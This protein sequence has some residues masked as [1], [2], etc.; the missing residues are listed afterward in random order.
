MRFH[1]SVE[2]RPTI[3]RP[4]E[5]LAVRHAIGRQIAKISASGKMIDG[6]IYADARG[7]FFIL[8]ID[9]PVEIMQLMAPAAHDYCSITCH[10]LATFEE[11][12]QVFEML[13][14]EEAHDRV[15]QN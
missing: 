11:L 14:R 6:G 8:D 13:A 5:V 9:S 2:L 1:I 3:T 7:G 4:E 12:G 10:P 15:S